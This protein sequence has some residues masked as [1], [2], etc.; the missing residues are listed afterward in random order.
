MSRNWTKAMEWNNEGTE[1]SANLKQN[2]FLGG[3]K[4]PASTFNY[5]L[6]KFK[7]CIDELQSAFDAGDENKVD[8]VAGKGLSTNDYT[9]AEKTKLAGIDENATSVGKKGSGTNSEIFNSAE[10]ATGDNA[11]AEGEFSQ[12]EG[13]CSHAEGYDTLASGGHS[14]AEGSSTQATGSSSHAEGFETVASG[15][16]AHAEGSYTKAIGGNS[17]AEGNNCEAKGYSSHAE[18]SYTKA[19]GVNSHAQGVHT[20][21]NDYQSVSGKYNADT[22][23][24]T[25]LTDTSG[26]LYIVGFGTSET[27]RKN[28]FRISAAGKCYGTTTFGSSGADYAEYF[29]WLDGNPN[30]EDRRGLFVTLDG[31]K[32]RLANSNDDFILGVVSAVPS[33]CGDIQSEYWKDRFL[34]DVFGSPIIETVKVPETVDEKTGETIPEHT[35]KRFIANPE[36]DYNKTYVSRENRKEWNAVGLVGKLVAIDDGTCEVNGYCKV[37]ENG[38]ATKSIEK[39]AFRILCRIDETHI[40]ILVK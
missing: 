33:I 38:V 12:A 37:S 23:A 29:E 1:P 6:H 22:S 35:E 8:K 31:E 4:P 20:I 10:S 39:T 15:S 3:Y 24:P 17:H 32:I 11:H 16:E 5:F 36:Y 30:N 14:H 26:S 9:T 25:S 19:N 2:G 13:N 21:A 40:K 18:G 34:K 27:D 7:V 28:A